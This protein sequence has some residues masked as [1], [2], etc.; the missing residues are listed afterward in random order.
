MQVQLKDNIDYTHFLQNVHQCEGEILLTTMENDKLNLKS[1]L[2]QYLFLAFLASGFKDG[3]LRAAYLTIENRQD[4][5][6]LRPFILR[7]EIEDTAPETT[8]A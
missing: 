1:Q 5:K 2:S 8:T 3:A 7:R 4:E 6:R